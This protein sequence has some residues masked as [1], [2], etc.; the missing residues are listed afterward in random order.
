MNTERQTSRGSRI[1]LLLSILVLA[2]AGGFWTAQQL[3]QR[4]GKV[5]ELAWT[6]FPEAREIASFDLLDHDS[7]P[8]NKASLRDRWSF[9]FFGYTHCP[10]VCPTTLSTLNSVAQRLEDSGP[11]VQFVFVS[12]DPQRDTPEQL[13]R[14]VRYFNGDFIGVTGT[15]EAI[16]Q[17]TRQ[18]GIMHM[19]VANE[20]GTGSYLIDHSAGVLLFDPDGRF[21]A[22]FTPPLSAED[23]AGA[24]RIMEKDFQ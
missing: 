16:D 24:L 11:P 19:Q 5:D 17:F 14:Y 7:K 4:P 21:H 18:L 3:L 10:D 2:M 15:E 23:M 6:R 9:V 8:F 1:L 22:V 12:V 20:T 13:A